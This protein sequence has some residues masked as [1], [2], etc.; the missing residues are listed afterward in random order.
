M[1]NFVTII[2]LWMPFLLSGQSDV[3]D[4]INPDHEITTKEVSSQFNESE[5]EEYITESRLKFHLD[6]GAFAGT[7]FGSGD[8][9]GTYVSPQI[10]YRLSPKFTLT[11]GMTLTN[12][13]GNPWYS[14]S[15]EG[16]YGYPSANFTRSFLYASGAY[17][18]S[19]RLVLSGTVYKEINLYNQDSFSKNNNTGDYH[20]M[21]MGVDYKIGKNIFIQ[22]QI[23][24]SNNPYRGY[25][26]HGFYNNTFGNSL[27]GTP[28][29]Y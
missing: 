14:C 13:I 11:A 3:M 29:P 8:Y 25:Q 19:E 24:I 28:Y 6:A 27:F 5:I 16:Q 7:S 26:Q 23:E 12:T 15:I 2:I 9:F 21:I 20:G 1:R 17:Q 18:L 22:G 10:N 4:Q